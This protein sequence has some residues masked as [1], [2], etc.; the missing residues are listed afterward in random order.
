MISDGEK[1][2]LL[3]GRWFGSIAPEFAAQLLAA[4]VPRTY[5]RGQW[6]FSRGDPSDGLYAM[7]GG[8]VRVGASAPNGKETLL[9]LLEPPVWFGEIGVF[10]RQ[11]RTHDAIAEDD[12]TVAHV[13]QPAL[14]TILAASPH[15][16]RDLALLATSKLRQAFVA[17]EAMAVQPLAVRLAGMLVV[18][19]ERYGELHDRSSRTIEL[20]QEQLAAMLAS[21]RQTVNTLLRDL[22]KRGI[23][24][25]AYGTIEILDKDALKAIAS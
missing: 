15:F 3:T 22:E 16:W 11:P 5:A 4:A 2:L 24:R 8:A 25:V 17:M 1:A 18:L 21:S 9:A 19:A 10:D 20:G 14:E 13:P 12:V 7:T 23:V 6:L